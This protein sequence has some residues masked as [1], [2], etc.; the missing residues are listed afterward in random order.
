MVELK[1]IT[2]ENF[3]QC[4]SLG[5]TDNQQDF[6]EDNVYA[7]AQA[8]VAATMINSPLSHTQYIMMRL[9]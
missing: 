8:Y 1:K 7:L 6:V 4:L 3:E 2:W 5:V 9:L